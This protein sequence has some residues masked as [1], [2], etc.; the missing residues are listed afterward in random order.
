M[1]MSIRIVA[2]LI[3]IAMLVTS[4]ASCGINMNDRPSGPS[5][6]TSEPAESSS[7]HDPDDENYYV[8]EILYPSVSVSSLKV[9]ITEKKLE[10]FK[11]KLA[12]VKRLFNEGEK[13]TENK[14]KNELYKLLSLEAAMETQYDTAHLLYYYDTQSSNAWNDYA[15]AYD[16]YDEANDLLWDFY[17]EYREKSGSFA[18]VLNDVFDKEFTSTVPV[19]EYSDYYADEMKAL[20]GEYNSL[21][22]SG[23]RDEKKIFVILK[24]YLVAAKGFAVAGKAENY[25]EYASK[26]TYGRTDTSEQRERLRDYT[27]EIL[28]PLYKELDKKSLEFNDSHSF[29][30]YNRTNR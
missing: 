20:E 29:F 18:D 8:Y 26:Y 2:L 9:D 10:E 16:L 23:S 3:C 13:G 4:F 5:G 19:S 17:N 14:F 30:E 22:N 24:D 21:V 25:Y 6:V 27:K 28:V 7:A 11:I 15:Y 12:L 1:R